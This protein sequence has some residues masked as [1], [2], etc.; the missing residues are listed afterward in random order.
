MEGDKVRS[1][2]EIDAMLSGG[3]ASEE[4]PAET[5]S[6]P[7]VVQ[8]STATEPPAAPA[9]I[10]I[11]VSPSLPVASE[12]GQDQLA[13]TGAIPNQPGDPVA[14]LNTLVTTVTAMAQQLGTAEGTLKQFDQL[15]TDISE[16]SIAV[17]EMKQGFQALEQQIQSLTSQVQSTLEGLKG[18][19]GYRAKQTFTCDSCNTSSMVATRIKC[20]HCG[21]ENWWGW[22][23][24][25]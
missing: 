1:Q 5:S 2:A 4:P 16:T 9:P 14:T 22:W 20:T 17:K 10:P 23:P 11:P 13:A 6:P 25:Q 19:F 18:T 8:L 24:P 12:N 7:Q 15:Q 21:K 3:S